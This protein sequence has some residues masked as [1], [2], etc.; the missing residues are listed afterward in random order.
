MRDFHA[1]P[2]PGPEGA[3]AGSAEGDGSAVM[4]SITPGGG[5]M[6]PVY[7]IYDEDPDKLDYKLITTAGG[8]GTLYAAGR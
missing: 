7:P 3:V 2:L 1:T 8:Q 6:Q 5:V 4:L